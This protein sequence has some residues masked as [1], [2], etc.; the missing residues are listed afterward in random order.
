[1]VNEMVS[2]IIP[3]YNREQVIGRSIASVLNQTYPY[4]ELLIVDDGSVDRTKQVVERI[5]DERIRYIALD[6]NQG[7]GRARNIGMQEARYDF[8]AF[9]DSDDEWMPEKLELQMEKM[10]HSIGKLRG[11]EELGAVYCRMDT[12]SRKTGERYIYPPVSLDKEILEGQIFNQLLVKNLIGMPTL[13]IRREC[14]EK[15][16]GFKESLK[17]LEDYEWI[18][19]IAEVYRIGLVEQPLLRVH[20]SAGSISLNTGAYVLTKCYLISKYRREMAEV[21]VLDKAETELLSL[22]KEIN[23]YEETKE[24]LTR[25]FEL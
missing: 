16:G 11:G 7:V 12:V 8:I 4:F 14:M 17:C 24:L 25:N 19:R 5:S 13:L 20:K 23:L 18:L 10:M 2:V 21:N 22:A 3:T 1:M 15:V 9:L 6:K